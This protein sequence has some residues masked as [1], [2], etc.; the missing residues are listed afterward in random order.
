MND[1]TA[2][3]IHGCHREAKNWDDIVFG[4]NDRFGRV[5]TG[6]NEAIKK[7]AQLIIWGSGLP[8]KN[9]I[10]ESQY[11]YDLSIGDKLEKLS[12]KIKW[13]PNTL[14]NHLTRISYLDFESKNTTEEI[15]VALEKCKECKIKN[16]ILISS[17][18]H[19]PRC[20]QQACIIQEKNKYPITLYASPSQ[21]CFADSKPEDVF[22]LEPPHRPEQDS[23]PPFY[24]TLRKL[25]EVFSNLVTAQYFHQDLVNLFQ[26]YQNPQILAEDK[27][28]A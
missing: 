2:V 21:T 24:K 20:L 25:F 3:L 27:K 19:L 7:N 15:R 14:K 1:S 6:I 11:I 18:T 4:E 13:D 23:L 22:I 26:K 17:P 12:S 28:V 16:L 5:P 9:G 10:H 8:D